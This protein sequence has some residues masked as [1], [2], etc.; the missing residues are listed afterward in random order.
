MTF[1]ITRFDCIMY[2][3]QFAKNVQEPSGIKR[4]DEAI[5][6]IT[7]GESSWTRFVVN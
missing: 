3:E 7:Q 5:T 1:E 6:S 4:H 2:P